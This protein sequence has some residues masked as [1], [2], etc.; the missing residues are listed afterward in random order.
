MGGGRGTLGWVS[1][2]EGC[3]CSWVHGWMGW[4]RRAFFLLWD[5]SGR[6]ARPP[7]FG[8][9]CPGNGFVDGGKP[10]I[11]FLFLFLVFTL[12]NRW[13]TACV[14][15]LLEFFL[16]AYWTS[17]GGVLGGFGLFFGGG[18]WW[19]CLVLA[20]LGVLAVFG[21][22]IARAWGAGR[23]SGHSLCA[24]GIFR[25]CG[26]FFVW[27]DEKQDTSGRRTEAP[28]GRPGGRPEDGF[29]ILMIQSVT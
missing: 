29:D 16:Y 18:A 28:G 17:M 13:A 15:F 26:F 7:F 9:V 23:A 6:V 11:F 3:L 27:V 5:C 20:G 21:G 25:C 2:E 4:K 8:L 1:C 10:S 14:G 22:D 12:G 19:P 24:C